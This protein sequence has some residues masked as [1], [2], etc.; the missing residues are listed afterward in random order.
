MKLRAYDPSLVGFVPYFLVIFRTTYVQY[1]ILLLQSTCNIIVEYW[2]NKEL[3][4]IDHMSIRHATVIW[5]ITCFYLELIK[6]SI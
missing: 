1:N 4:T 2:I 6:Q 3:Q 5:K